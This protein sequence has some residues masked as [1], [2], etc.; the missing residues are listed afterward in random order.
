MQKREVCF[1][2]MNDYL[3]RRGEGFPIEKTSFSSFY[4]YHLAKNICSP[5][6]AL[7]IFQFSIHDSVEHIHD[8]VEYIHSCCVITKP[9]SVRFTALHIRASLGWPWVSSPSNDEYLHH[10]M[11]R[12]TKEFLEGSI[13][14]AYLAKRNECICMYSQPCLPSHCQVLNSLQYAETGGLFLSHEWLPR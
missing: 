9:T 7:I 8:S 11:T 4:P 13:F 12:S 14:R 3:G 10:P 1:Y 6:L 2:H 5:D